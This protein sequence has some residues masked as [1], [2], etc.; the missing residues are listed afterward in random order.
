MMPRP[1]LSQ[2][3]VPFIGVIGVIGVIRVLYWILYLIPLFNP[4]SR[5][6]GCKQS[7]AKDCDQSGVDDSIKR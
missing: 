4:S 1:G 6:D 5:C 3:L 2:L 7:V